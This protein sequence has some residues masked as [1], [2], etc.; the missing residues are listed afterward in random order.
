[1][2]LSVAWDGSAIASLSHRRPMLVAS[3]AGI[4]CSVCPSGNRWTDQPAGPIRAIGGA[5][6]T[7]HPTR[8]EAEAGGLMSYGPSIADAYRQVGVYTGR[9]LKGDKPADLP[10]VQSSK[11]ELVIKPRP[12]GCLASPCPRSPLPTR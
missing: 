9:I 6:P 4:L 7:T 12:R 2:P 8:P 11:F 3:D 1:M 10:V 5:V